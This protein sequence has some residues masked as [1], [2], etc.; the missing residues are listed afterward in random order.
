MPR[1][2][3]SRA[4]ARHMSHDAS[5]AP[6]PRG[7]FEPRNDCSN[8]LTDY[9]ILLENRSCSERDSLVLEQP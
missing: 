8:K 3:L 1:G 4:G 5:T 2:T 9:M 7:T 6:G